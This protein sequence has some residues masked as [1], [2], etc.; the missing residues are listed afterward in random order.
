M[1]SHNLTR[2]NNQMIDRVVEAGVGPNL[3]NWQIGKL[4]AVLEVYKPMFHDKG[5]D[6]FIC[7]KDEY[8]YYGE[9]G[10]VEH[11]RWIEYVDREVQPNYYPQRS[12]DIKKDCVIL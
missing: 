1:E 10:D 6:I 8:V 11:Y 2:E 12:A 3:N 9:Y 5:V 4:K 7:P